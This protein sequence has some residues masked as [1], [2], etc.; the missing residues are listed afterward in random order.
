M[1]F[2]S[3]MPTRIC[4]PTLYPA[5]G[6]VSSWTRARSSWV[7]CTQ[8]D[9]LAAA[10]R[11]TMQNDGLGVFLRA[12]RAKAQADPA[13]IT[14]SGFRRVPGLRREEV[15]VLAGLSVDYYTR[16]EQGRE[17]HPSEQVLDALAR[18]LD[19]NSDAR[20]H[21]FR[22]ASRVAPLGYDGSNHTVSD[23]LITLMNAWLTTPAYVLNRTMDI[24]AENDLAKALHSGLAETDN[25]ARMTFLDPAGRDFYVDWERAAHSA[26]GH[27]RLAAGHDPHDPRL[28]ALLDELT[29]RSAA[30]RQLWNRHDV[31][32]KTREPKQFRH[33]DV[34]ILTLTYEALDIRSDP[35]LQLIVHHAPTDSPSGESLALLGSL[36]ASPKRVTD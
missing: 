31:R 10:Y 22:L 11:R 1:S 23:E 35:G 33:P 2:V 6:V 28:L 18:A 5:S 34:G 15:A 27:L 26:T 8:E 29:R 19:L 3:M 20:T 7:R 9:L 32:G 25:L 17:R 13:A 36:A 30:F 14:G 24:L 4:S 16:L 21:L 12:Q